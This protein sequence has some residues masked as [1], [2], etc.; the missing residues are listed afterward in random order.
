M[1]KPP[2]VVGKGVALFLVALGAQD[3]QVPTRERKGWV[4][5]AGEDVIGAHYPF[6]L[7][8][9]LAHQTPPVVLAVFPVGFLS[10]HLPF[11]G[12][13]K[14]PGF[15]GGYSRMIQFPPPVSLRMASTRSRSFSE[16]VPADAAIFIAAAAKI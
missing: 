1:Q 12:L 14:P 6:S 16:V 13:Q 15:W 5:P 9:R 3:L 2:E 8:A 10:H 11:R 4:I 7:A